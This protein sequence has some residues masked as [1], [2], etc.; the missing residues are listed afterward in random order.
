MID[1]DKQQNNTNQQSGEESEE[2]QAMTSDSTAEINPNVSQS[3]TD[4][5]ARQINV[6]EDTATQS[7]DNSVAAKGEGASTDFTGKEG[8]LHQQIE[9]LKAQL[10]ERTTQ[11]MRIVADFEN[12]RKRNQKEKEDLEQQIKRNTIN[13]LLPIVDNF[14]RARAQ[15]KPQNDGEM[16]IHK[17][18]Q[19]VYKLL[20]DSLK[21]LGVS[22]MRPE[23][24]PFDPNLHEA[25]LREPTD[26]YPEGTVLEELVRGYYL[27][28]RV[29]RHAMVK[30]A[31]PKEDG[32]LNAENSVESSQ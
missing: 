30:V 4:P 8:A 12:Y 18:Y 3:E 2:K 23:T 10:E 11:Y 29:L 13:E 19:G 14:E 7:Q 27:G 15:I 21:R 24:Q 25:V 32:P 6:S 5:V 20:V 26:E 9:S 16:T 31:A 1:E 28:D 17:S 22:P